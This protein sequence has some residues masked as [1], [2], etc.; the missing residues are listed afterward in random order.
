MIKP[1]HIPINV[2]A[3]FDTVWEMTRST[4]KAIAAAINA[5]PNVE[6][7]FITEDE[8]IYSFILPMPQEKN[9]E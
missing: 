1:E 7:V 2:S 4:E 6:C 3:T 9:D 8:K 5:W